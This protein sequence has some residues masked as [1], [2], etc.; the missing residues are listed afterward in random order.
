MSGIYLA[1]IRMTSE[2]YFAIV[3]MSEDI[4]KR[5]PR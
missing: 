4:N 1:L 3:R 2:F 5:L